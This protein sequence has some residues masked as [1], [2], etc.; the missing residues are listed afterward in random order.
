MLTRSSI[1][2]PPA[3]LRRCSARSAVSAPMGGDRSIAVALHTSHTASEGASRRA[4]SVVS[5]R[6]PSAMYLGLE[7]MPAPRHRRESAVR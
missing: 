2:G 1:A 3:R 5:G 6:S 4:L 7:P